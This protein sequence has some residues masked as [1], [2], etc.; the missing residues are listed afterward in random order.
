MPKSRSLRE[1]SPLAMAVK[2]LGLPDPRVLAARGARA[3]ES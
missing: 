3:S 1:R 2:L